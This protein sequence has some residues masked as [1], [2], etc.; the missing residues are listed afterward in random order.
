MSGIE[1][2]ALQDKGKQAGLLWVSFKNID[3]HGSKGTPGWIKG[4]ALK[5]ALIAKVIQTELRIGTKHYDKAGTRL[6]TFDEVIRAYQR[7]FGY[8][9]DVPSD[10][11]WKEKFDGLVS[12]YGIEKLDG[13]GKS[14]GGVS[15]L[16]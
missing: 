4:M 14:G 13:N 8:F 12:K 9:I 7:D 15:P 6:N 16:S 5:G 2:F 11:A 3:V 10:K 1:G